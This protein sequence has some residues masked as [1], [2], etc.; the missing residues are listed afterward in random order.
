MNEEDRAFVKKIEKERIEIKNALLS[1]E[2]RAY[3]ERIEMKSERKIT[4]HSESSVHSFLSLS[5]TTRKKLADAEDGIDH[6]PPNDCGDY[7]EDDFDSDF[8]DLDKY[9]YQK[10]KENKPLEEEEVKLNEDQFIARKTFKK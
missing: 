8:D 1:E 6:Y 5:S 3:R 10:K 2:E 4:E 7:D 9:K